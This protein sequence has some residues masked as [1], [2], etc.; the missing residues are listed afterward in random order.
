ML[1]ISVHVVWVF[2]RLIGRVSVC[3]STGGREGCRREENSS[4]AI[5]AGGRDYSRGF[6]HRA[7]QE[8]DGEWWVGMGSVWGVWVG[9]TQYGQ[10]VC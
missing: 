4:K 9:L 1:V 7:S 10:W 3:V 2:E 6:E 5:L 8:H